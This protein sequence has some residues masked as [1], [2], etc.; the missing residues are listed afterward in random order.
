VTA[1][2]GDVLADVGADLVT[3]L[4]AIGGTPYKNPAWTDAG[5]L[6]GELLLDDGSGTL[7]DL[8]ISLE[9]LDAATTDVTASFQGTEIDSGAAGDI[10]QLG[11]CAGI[12]TTTS[13]LSLRLSLGTDEV[14]ID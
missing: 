11:L 13:P 6:Y 1:G 5:A 3:A 2:A 12:L 7:G 9:V 14:V 10:L 8:E 4:A